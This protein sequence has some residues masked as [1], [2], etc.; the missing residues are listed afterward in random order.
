MCLH[1]DACT[2]CTTCFIT[3][4]V[5]YYAQKTTN[6]IAVTQPPYIESIALLLHM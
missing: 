5:L 3:N 2:V 6:N 1:F 4:C